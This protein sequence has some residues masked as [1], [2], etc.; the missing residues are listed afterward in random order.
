[1]GA[2]GGQNR[3]EAVEAEARQLREAAKTHT[4]ML[5]AAEVEAQ[6]LRDEVCSLAVG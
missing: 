5:E 4:E 6:E 3:L 2:F 1:M